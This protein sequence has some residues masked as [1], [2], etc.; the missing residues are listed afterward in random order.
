MRQLAIVFFKLSSALQENFS[1]EAL[2]ESL[3]VIT[4]ASRKFEE[5]SKKLKSEKY[6]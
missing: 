6:E 4:E 2:N 5:I 1:E 3:S